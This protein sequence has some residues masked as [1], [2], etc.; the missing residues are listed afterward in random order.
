MKRNENGGAKAAR[1]LRLV[2]QNFICA[3]ATPLLN[4]VRVGTHGPGDAMPARTVVS[5]DAAM[6]AGTA[7]RPVVL[8]VDD[9]PTTRVYLREALSAL[10]VELRI[11]ETAA[12]FRALRAGRRPDLSILDV[13]LPDGGGLALAEEI[14]AAAEPMVFFSVHDDGRH[15]MKALETGAV[16]YLVKP[17]GPREFS[18]RIANLL[19]HTRAASRVECPAIRHFAD[20]AFDPGTRRLMP[21]GGPALRL[22]ASE[23]VVLAALTEAPH[24]LV[25]REA[26]A[27]RLAGG[28]AARAPRI[29]DVLVYRLRRKLREAGAD[30]NLILTVP[31]RGYT[32]SA[33]VT[34]E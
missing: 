18:L 24:A 17:I 9:D 11:A 29:V 14:G 12:G 10:P 28:G 23:A 3:G 5:D 6:S 2:S 34:A 13:D 16:D 1:H 22:T 33:T 31:S 8:A 19:A 25:T 32:L 20:L 27:A 30:P 21:A 15:R 4:F 7:L 26:L